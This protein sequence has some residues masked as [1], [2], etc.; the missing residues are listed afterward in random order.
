MKGE[1]MG[2]SGEGM[3]RSEG[4]MGYAP[5]QDRDRISNICSL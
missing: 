5:C 2:R 4:G 3:G 1:G